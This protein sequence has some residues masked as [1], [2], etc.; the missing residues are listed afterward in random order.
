MSDNDDSLLAPAA[1]VADGTPI[2]WAVLESG[3]WSPEQKDVIRRLRTLADLAAVHRSGPEPRV[4]VADVDAATPVDP[5]PPRVAESFTAL[6]KGRYMIERSLGKGGFGVVYQAY[7]HERQAHIA[8][9]SLSRSDVGS[10]YYLKNEFR[11]L[12]DLSHPNLVSLYELFADEGQW[13]IAMELVRGSDFLSYVR[14]AAPREVT[15]SGRGD[16]AHLACDLTRLEAA[17]SQ[18]TEALC[19]LHAHGKLH[20]DIKPSNVLVTEAGH[21]KVLDFDLTADLVADLRGGDTVRI[22]GNP[23][24]VSPEQA[25]GEP[26]SEASDWYSVGVILFESL[27]GQ[28]PFPGTYLEVLAA[29]QQTEAPE[30]AARRILDEQLGGCRPSLDDLRISSEVYAPRA[31]PQL[32]HHWDLEFL[33]RGTIAE[34]ELP[35]S[36]AWTELRFVETSSTNASEFSRSHDEV[37]QK[38]GFPIRSP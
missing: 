8:L 18:L 32:T 27:T 14:G 36:T 20:R 10:L 22:R 35:R 7:D 16:G 24:Y 29:K 30:A 6:K 26:P 25:I 2:D 1:A 9:K 34:S 15:D 11:R 5:R 13:F 4:R 33:F 23:A 12:A 37:L 17:L 31:F 28:R 38:A 3:A 19:Y 21:L